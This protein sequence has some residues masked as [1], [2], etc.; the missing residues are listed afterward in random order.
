MLEKL[1]AGQ[2]LVKLLTASSAGNLIA[3]SLVTVLFASYIGYEIYR[4][5]WKYLIGIAAFIVVAAALISLLLL[6]R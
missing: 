1:F 6:T 2:V 3:V 5:N 4:K